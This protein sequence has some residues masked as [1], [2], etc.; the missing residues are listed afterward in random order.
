M[1]K[2]VALLM[3]VVLLLS[4]CAC[5]STDTT[6]KNEKSDSSNSDNNSAE[7]KPEKAEITF[8]ESV[9]VD[10]ESCVFK[11]VGI[12]PDNFWGY[13][14]KTELEN[15]S[16]DKTYTFSVESASIN[17]VQCDPFFAT[18]V[19]AGK[20]ARSDISFSDKVLQKNGVGDYTDIELTVRVYDSS[21]WDADDVARET[22]HIYPYGQEKAVKYTREAQDGDNVVIDNEYVTA[23][24]TGY[25]VDEIWG[26]TV[27][28]FLINKTDKSVMFSANDVSVNGF[29]ADPF[30][31]KTVH[32]GKC[33]F[34][35]MSWS[36]TT[37]AEN[38]ITDV[39]EI[40]FVFRIY[41]WNNWGTPEFAN[42][43]ITLNPAL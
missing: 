25:E 7:S 39:E 41:D 14:L 23:V 18:D 21:E 13:T 26:Y 33:T 29:M 24:V 35:S 10:N 15:K 31:G 42:E 32:A 9:A 40:E 3:A 4:F 43:K 8:T 37:L 5:S 38:Q 34:A 2:I 27:N 22:V 30:F 1:Q 6:S 12:E 20:K 36:D 11:I 16:A 19:A 28:L 17:G